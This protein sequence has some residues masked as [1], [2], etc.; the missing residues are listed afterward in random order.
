MNAAAPTSTIVPAHE[1]ERRA[2]LAMP[3]APVADATDGEP[4]APVPRRVMLARTGRWLGHPTAREIVT[5][6][7]LRSALAYFKRH[8]AANGADLVIDYHHASVVVP[9]D[10]ARAPAAGWIRELTLRNGDT[11][12]WADVLWTDEAAAAIARRQYR[13]V[14]PVF[15]FHAP[16]RITGL[17][18][19]MHIHSAALTNTPFITELEALNHVAGAEAGEIGS[20][21]C[22]P[23][24]P[25]EGGGESMSLLDSL[26]RALDRRPEQVASV[27]GLEG[28]DD[29]LVAEAVLA[30]AARVKEL[31]APT[32]GTPQ[33]NS[34]AADA[35]GLPPDADE[36]S[37]RA[38]IVRL[39][40]PGAGLDRV[41]DGL[42]L[43]RQAG[44]VEILNAIGALQAACRSRQAE[45]LVDEAIAAGKVPP[46]H[47]DFYLREAE[48][49]LET[50]RDVINSLPVLTARADVPRRANAH[51]ADGL[52]PGER[53]LCRQLGL[54]AAAYL[55][56]AQQ[57]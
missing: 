8:Y 32:S 31:E 24:V 43:P 46:A 5:R 34:A 37:V 25:Q 56:A 35:L 26:A 20:G 42:G 11:E 19:L 30:N 53:D 49:D 2:S 21:P 12:L 33:L 47:R 27:L 3:L 28:A 15:R 22:A 55:R 23:A 39:K 17:P 45:R 13:Y 18:V 38:A 44:E 54:S 29:R 7:A 41:R 48:A 36:R 14:S 51:V 6:A 16:D 50:V 52:T 9:R 57:A 1:T 4:G 10:G 40:A